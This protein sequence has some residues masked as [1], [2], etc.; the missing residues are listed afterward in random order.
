[1]IAPLWREGKAWE[2]VT[3]H[4]HQKLMENEEVLYKDPKGKKNILNQKN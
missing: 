4:I 1:M 2:D 3:Y